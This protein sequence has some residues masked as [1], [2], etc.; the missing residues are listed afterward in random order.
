MLASALIQTLNGLASA[1]LLF[2]VALGLTLIFGVMRI[3]NFAHGSFFML[4]AYVAV[5]FNEAVGGGVTGFWGGALV[6]GLAVAAIGLLV[7]LVVLRRIYRAPELLQLV[8]TFGIVLIIKDVTLGIWGAEDILGPRAPGLTGAVAIFGK[9]FPTYDLLLLFLGPAMLVGIWL[10]LDRTIWGLRIRAATEDRDMAAALGIDQAV[11]FSSVFALGAFLAGLA[12]ALALPR[13]PASLE[14]D[15]ATIADVFVVTVVG[16]LGSLPGA[17]AAAVLI[18]VVKS[19][20]IGLGTVTIGGS[21]ISFTKLTIVAEFLVMAAVLLVRPWG[22]F[23]RQPA[24]PRVTPGSALPLHAL[25]RKDWLLWGAVLAGLLVLPLVVDRYSLVLMTDVAAF[26]L[27]ASS[28]AILM[29]WA[30]MASFGH[31]AYFGAGAYG[32]ALAALA[33]WPFAFALVAGVILA[34]FLAALYGRLALRAEG[35]SLAMLTLAF[36]QITWAVAFQWDAVTGGSNGLIGIWPPQSLS[37]S[38]AYFICAVLICGAAISGVWWLAHSSFGYALRAT[39]D[40][41]RRA[42]ASGIEVEGLRWAAFILSGTLAGLAGAVYVFAKGSLSPDV[43]SIPRSVDAL[44]MVLIGGVE[45]LAGPLGGAL[46]FTWLQ[47]WVARAV[48]YWQALLGAAIVLLTILFPHGISGTLARRR[49]TGA[50]A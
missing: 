23:G 50:M 41:Q 29:G 37:S 32:A 48:P 25:Q 18:S 24:E 14:L 39:R 31:A 3:V 43:L 38:W 10:L 1:S 19:W 33:G 13:Q 22:L 34:G 27:L 45:T 9:L 2:L 44:V 47:D 5:S 8:A 36:A 17:Y 7:E 15:L 11:L 30:G 42:A 21:A 46:V 20:C 26:A 12:G 6:A 40:H 35:I 16:G 49:R 4:G 28:L